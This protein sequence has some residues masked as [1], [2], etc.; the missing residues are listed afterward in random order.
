VHLEAVVGAVAGLTD[1]GL[2]RSN[3]HERRGAGRDRTFDRGIMSP[4][5]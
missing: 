1:F 2:G 4:L 3:L 5:L